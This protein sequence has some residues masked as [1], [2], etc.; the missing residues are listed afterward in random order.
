MLK[1]KLPKGYY[2]N[3][4]ENNSL[5]SQPTLEGVQGGAGYNVTR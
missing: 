5:F 2:A 3:V 1:G 4:R